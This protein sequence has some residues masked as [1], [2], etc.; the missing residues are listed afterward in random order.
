MTIEEQLNRIIKKRMKQSL[1]ILKTAINHNTPTKD[2]TLIK[3]TKIIDPVIRWN[4][5]IW[6][7]I[8]KVDHAVIVEKGTWTIFKYHKGPPTNDSTV[9]TI[10]E[11]AHMFTR[12]LDES[13]LNIINIMNWRWVIGVLT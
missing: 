10:W 3:W 4:K 1:R 6:K 12:W 13:R 8:N 9:F 7:V 5:I 11:W 2:F